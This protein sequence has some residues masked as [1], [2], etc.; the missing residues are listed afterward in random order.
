MSNLIFIPFQ[1]YIKSLCEIHK[2]VLHVDNTNVCF[3]RMQSEDEINNIKSSIG[4]FLVIISS[5]T[6][7]AIGAPDDNML[8]QHAS[9]MFVTRKENGTGI[10]HN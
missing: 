10:S 7:R 5:F 8:Q 9:I 2:D 3:V 4:G 1:D 6:G